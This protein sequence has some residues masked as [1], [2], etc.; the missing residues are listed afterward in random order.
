[1][2]QNLGTIVLVAVLSALAGHGTSPI[3]GVLGGAGRAALFLTLVVPFGVWILP[4]LFERVAALHNR[5][6][7][8]L[9]VA[10][11]A[12]GMPMRRPSSVCPWLSAFLWALGH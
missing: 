8:V 4:W 7:F 1:M 6:L 9:L 11:V 3:M 5:E 2:V 12:L 10:S